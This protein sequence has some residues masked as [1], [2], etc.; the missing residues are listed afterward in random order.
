MWEANFSRKFISLEGNQS[1]GL[2]IFPFFKNEKFAYKNLRKILR[3][4]PEQQFAKIFFLITSLCLIEAEIQKLPNDKSFN[5]VNSKTYK[6]NL[7][8]SW[9]CAIVLALPV[10]SRNAHKNK[11]EE[12][13]KMCEN[14]EK[15]IIN[16]R[17]SFQL[18]VT[19]QTSGDEAKVLSN[20]FAGFFSTDTPKDVFKAP[21]KKKTSFIVPFF[22]YFVQNW[23]IKKGRVGIQ[24]VKKLWR[25]FL[26]VTTPLT[27]IF[28]VFCAELGD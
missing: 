14:G 2:R 23:A 5:G 20:E 10:T 26:V 11:S 21:N 27:S 13:L 24:S 12:N 9:Q 7:F 6:F 4:S 19:R 17:I 22:K 15:Q 28:Q 25:Y 1:L 18:E 16:L 3:H 8:L